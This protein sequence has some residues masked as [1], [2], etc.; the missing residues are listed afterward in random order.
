MAYYTYFFIVPF[1]TDAAQR[2]RTD[3][4]VGCVSA[5]EAMARAEEMA[6]YAEYGGAVAVR[7][8]SRDGKLSGEPTVLACY[9][10]VSP[11]IRTVLREHIR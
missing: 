10:M 6:R 11:D 2:A 1:D 5:S 8:R 3:G 9:G 7:A 4:I